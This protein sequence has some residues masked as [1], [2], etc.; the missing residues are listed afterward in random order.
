S[1]LTCS[2]RDA[3]PARPLA[4]LHGNTPFHSGYKGVRRDRGLRSLAFTSCWQ[5][6]ALHREHCT[7][8]ML[9]LLSV[10][11]IS[12]GVSPPRF[13][14]QSA[15]KGPVQATACHEISGCAALPP[16]APDVVK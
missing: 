14:V 16:V 11:C 9:C 1:G 10:R 5:L 8:S 4:P 3:H 2:L 13:A 12:A 6:S 15:E 7:P